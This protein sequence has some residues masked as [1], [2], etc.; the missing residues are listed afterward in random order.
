MS[1]HI[2]LLFALFSRGHVDL[3]PAGQIKLGGCKLSFS[4]DFRKSKEMQSRPFAAAFNCMK[5]NSVLSHS[6]RFLLGTP[7]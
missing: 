3:L 1:D 4:K 5:T 6:V 7:D 2:A